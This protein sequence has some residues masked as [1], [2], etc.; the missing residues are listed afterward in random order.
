MVLCQVSA[1][2]QGVHGR[3]SYRPGGAG[4]ETGRSSTCTCLNAGYAL[5][6]GFAFSIFCAAA[7]RLKAFIYDAL[8]DETAKIKVRKT[9]V[10]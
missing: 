3:P 9:I 5:A 6:T 7:N 1:S 10:P 2:A 8:E 4:G